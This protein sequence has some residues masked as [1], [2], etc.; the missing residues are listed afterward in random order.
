MT[1]FQ[2]N[3]IRRFLGDAEMSG[4]IKEVLRSRF[5]EK[6]QSDVHIL[7]SQTLAVQ[8]LEE[9]WVTMNTYR[10]REKITDAPKQIGM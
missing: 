3:K 5:L 1:E 9:A 7:A 8:M 4:V 2:I 10:E 6:R